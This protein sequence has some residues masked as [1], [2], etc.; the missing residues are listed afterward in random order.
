MI[1]RHRYLSFQMYTSDGKNDSVS[2]SC[3][4]ITDKEPAL[5][6]TETYNGIAI[7]GHEPKYSLL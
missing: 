2:V 1:Q 7:Q 3:K 4:L 5:S 6:A